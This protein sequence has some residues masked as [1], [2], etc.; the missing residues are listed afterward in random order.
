MSVRSKF[1]LSFLLAPLLV[2]G[3]A[4]QQTVRPDA[5]IQTTSISQASVPQKTGNVSVSNDI[6][7]AC[8][9]DFDNVDRAPKFDTDESSLEPQDQ[10]VLRQVATCVTT[11][12][13]KGRSL[14]LTGRADPRGEVEFNFVLG[15]HRAGTVENYLSSLGVAKSKLRE[16]S[17]GKLDATG[18]DTDS[19]ERDRRVDIT[20][21]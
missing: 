19:W 7:Q 5:A 13:L 11:G 15:E 4:H 20:L 9:V 1:G 10:S 16:T 6:A 12:P 8:K 18:T 3:C 2:G 17:R 14:E 21:Q